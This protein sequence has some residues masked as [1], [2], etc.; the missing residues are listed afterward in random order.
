[1]VAF[2]VSTLALSFIIFK[3]K[4]KYKSRHYVSSTERNI[5]FKPGQW[6]I[7]IN[8]CK[9]LATSNNNKYFH[10]KDTLHEHNNSLTKS[11]LLVSCRRAPRTSSWLRVLALATQKYRLGVHLLCPGD[12]L[13]EQGTLPPLEKLRPLRCKKWRSAM[14]KTRPRH[15]TRSK[16]TTAITEM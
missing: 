2:G 7:C 6:A 16:H 12:S 9:M 11:M 14:G 13:P 3:M 4:W 8:K 5:S 15:H 1:M 10:I